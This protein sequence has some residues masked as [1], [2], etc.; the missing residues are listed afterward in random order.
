MLKA[1]VVG[2]GGIGKAHA[3]ALSAV[4]DVEIAALVDTNLHAAQ[5]A[6]TQFGGQPYNHVADLPDDIHLATVATPPMS[7]YEPVRALLERRI[8]VLCEKPLTMDVAQAEALAT[9][10]ETGGVPLLVGF[11]MRFEPVFVR[12]RQVLPDLGPL[13]AVVSTKMQPYH[14]H[15]GTNWYPHVGA[16]YELSIHDFDLIRYI[17]GLDPQSVRAALSIPE[18]WTREKGFQIGVRYTGDTLGSHTGLYVDA[19]QFMYRDFVAQFIGERG[20]M[21][22]ERPDRISLHLDTFQV[23]EVPPAN[24]DAFVAEMTN[25]RDAVLGRTAPAT[26][27]RDGLIATRLVEAAFASGQAQGQWIPCVPDRRTSPGAS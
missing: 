1:A 24:T 26:C 25:F 12:A 8:P 9:L 21:L 3:R 16:M 2:C 17:S 19:C 10:S 5:G 4:E 15:P 7:H 11:K 18:G 6:A 22:V 13:R 14:A 20:Y 27:A 23:A